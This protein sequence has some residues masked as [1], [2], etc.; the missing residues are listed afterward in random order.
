[1][2]TLE[3]H[4]EFIPLVGPAGSKVAAMDIRLQR[5]LAFRQHGAVKPPTASTEEDEVAV[6]AKVSDADAFTSLSEVTPG[7][8]VGDRAEDGTTLLTARVA[9]SRV[10]QVRN[11]GYVVSMKAAQ[12]LRP[13]LAATTKDV[14]TPEIPAASGVAGGEGIIVAI[15]DSGCDFVHEN[16]RREDGSTRLLKFWD[17]A[18]NG[19]GEPGFAYGTV[20]DASAIDAALEDDSPY[21]ALGY[22]PGAAAHGTHVMDIA[23]GNGRG[24]GVP[25]VAPESDLL[26]VQ[27][28]VNDIPW[29]GEDVVGHSFGDSVQMLE[30][31]VWIFTTAGDTPCSVNIS[32]GT[33]GGPHDGT[34][35]FE[36]GVD[37]LLAQAPDRSVCIAASNSFDD[38]I[39]AAGT[40]PTSGTYELRWLIPADDR[41]HNELELWYPGR[42]ALTVELIE[43]SGRSLGTLAPGES[44]TAKHDGK[45]ILFAA[46]RT[47]DPNNGDNTVGVFL[48]PGAPPGRWVLRLVNNTENE[49][50]FHAWIER[51]DQGQSTFEDHFDNS[52]TVGSISC[53][54]KPIVVGSYDAHKAERPI[55]WFSSAGPTRDG[56]NKPEISAPGHD[57]IAA[58]SSTNRGVT[59][60]SGT[61]MAAPAVTGCIALLLAAAKA[62]QERIDIDTIR[63]IVITTAKANPPAPGGWHARYGYGRAAAALMID[64]LNKP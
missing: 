43:P 8:T 32:L 64:Q 19:A 30:A 1:M 15:V 52:H 58:S 5:L 47:G 12:P 55:S 22:N 16:F 34:T 62:R 37:R 27:P 60:K 6:I 17:Q 57:V 13:T 7:V 21:S 29:V 54:H 56:R 38:G 48:A 50:P 59:R 26:F 39:H 36:E 28:A 31:L 2:T 53:G 40:V 18:G 20:H 25:G 4:F 11:L 35:L 45:V 23:A 44:A 63:D 10:N 61:S 33:N 51:D 9:L 14:G 24:S 46:N 41:T 42:N 3:S 49:T